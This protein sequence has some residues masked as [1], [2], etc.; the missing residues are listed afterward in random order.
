MIQSQKSSAIGDRFL[1]AKCA[2]IGKYNTYFAV[3]GAAPFGQCVLREEP[4]VG[5]GHCFYMRSCGRQDPQ[6]AGTEIP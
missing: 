1:T 3:V 4:P 5:K 2:A 6:W